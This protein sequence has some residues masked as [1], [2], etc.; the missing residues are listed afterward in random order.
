MPAGKNP[1]VKQAKIITANRL[2]HEN[3]LVLKDLL[4]E[5]HIKH[6]NTDRV[7]I[8]PKKS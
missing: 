4:Y 5:M 2:N 1:T 3:W 7:R 8:I 6:R